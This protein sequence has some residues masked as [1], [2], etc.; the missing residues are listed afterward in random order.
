MIRRLNE[1]LNRQGANTEPIDTLR[2]Q[3]AKWVRTIAEPIISSVQAGSET[4]DP[5]LNLRAKGRMDAM[6]RVVKEI[7]ADQANRRTEAV[8][9]WH[10]E[11][12]HTIE[13]LVGSVLICRPADWH[14]CL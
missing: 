3:H 13:A 1:G 7:I 9:R 5:G 4:R 14:L 2:S 6:R 12:H 8:D 10:D 11:L